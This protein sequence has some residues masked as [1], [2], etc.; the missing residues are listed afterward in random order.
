V[1]APARQAAIVFTDIESFTAQA[2]E[3]ES[4]ALQLLTDQ[5]EVLRPIVAHH[6]G[7]IVKSLGDGL[8]L[9][10]P[11][12]GAALQGSVAIQRSIH[13]RN[14]RVRDLP[15]RLRVGI[16]VGDVH[17]RGTD[18]LGDTVNLASRIQA[19]APPGGICVSA[20]VFQQ[21][22]SSS[23]NPLKSLGLRSIKGIPEPVELY[24]VVLPWESEVPPSTEPALPRLAVLPLANISPD[25]GDAYFADG[26]T[27]ELISVLSRIRGL[28]VIAR[29]SVMPYKEAGKTIV[30][31]GSELGVT[32]VL[33]GSVR[34]AGDKIRIALQLVDV[35]TQE[36][37]W[38]QS[39]DRDFQDVF[40]IQSEIAEA[41]AAALEVQLRAAD[42]KEVHR[43]P[44]ANLDAYAT[45][46]RGVHLISSGTDAPSRA[47]REARRCFEM[48][49]EKDPS[50]V[51]AL[52]HL[53]NA[54]VG[55]TDDLPREAGNRRARELVT[56]ALALDPAS[57]DAHL[58]LGH[59]ARYESLDWVRAAEE[60]ETSIRLNPSNGL[61]HF[62]RGGLHVL[63]QDYAR[64]RSELGLALAVDPANQWAQVELAIVL[65]RRGDTPAA[66]GLYRQLQDRY[67]DFLWPHMGYAWLHALNGE[68]GRARE[69]AARYASVEE[70]TFR[71]FHAAIMF[72]L[73]D[74]S[75]ARGLLG[76]VEADPQRGLLPVSHVAGLQAMVGDSDA[77]LSLLE[78]DTRSPSPGLVSLYGYQWEWFDPI[79][80][81]P[82][83]AALLRSLRLPETVTW[84]HVSAELW[85][86]P[87]LPV[88]P[89][90]R[91]RPP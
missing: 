65:G 34:K 59:L 80:D 77:A 36:H 47:I 21:V 32:A 50:F 35:P 73:G 26:L 25:P 74:D 67:P 20:Q 48:A 3:D 45:Y 27:E 85:K 4:V 88:G 58:T 2:H 82:R 75:E 63:L 66:L 72:L 43:R 17:S 70:P 19:L 8:L 51:S 39:F 76:E 54:L 5:E 46:L 30:Q 68:W 61:A 38:S 69:E 9:E 6:G 84:R 52:C 18:V 40:A 78:R 42:R 56:R 89:P 57:S 55:G 44:T 13:A 16:H 53:A 49:A 11:D 15:L 91:G 79:R 37:V 41:S 71:F 24:R 28:R 81:D 1:G 90:A 62:W 23:S 31:I 29:A 83:F 14:Q 12:A 22:R 33:A 86:A 10:F 7:R 64:A 87:T 60:Y